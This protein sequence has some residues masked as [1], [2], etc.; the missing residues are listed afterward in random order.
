MP[1]S[2]FG[3]GSISPEGA[4]YIQAPG[5]LSS[6]TSQRLAG[7]NVSGEPLQ[8]WAGPPGLAVGA[9]Y[10]EEFSRSEF[11]PLQQAGLNAG[12]AI[13][14]TEGNFNVL[15]EYL[16][17]NL[18]LL[19]DVPFAD[20]LDFRGAIRLSDYST[21]GNTQSWNA[22]LGWSP[23]PSLRFRAIRAESVRAPNINE[24]YSPPSQNFPTGLND[25]CLGTTPTS[26]REQDEAC[27][28]A[29]GVMENIAANGGVFTLNQSDLQGISGYD[30]GNP[31]LQ[32][33][34]GKSWTV[35]VVIQPTGIPVLENFGFTIDYF[36]IQI[37]DAI[38]ST[39]CQFILDQCYSG[40]ASFCQ[41]ITRRPT[42]VGANSAGSLDLIDSAVTNSGGL[43]SESIALTVNY[44]QQIGPG[45]FR[46]RLS[47]THVLEGYTIPAA[48]ADKDP[49]AGEVGGSKD[50]AYLQL[51]YNWGQVGIAWNV[52]YIDKAYLDDQFLVGIVDAN[53]VAWKPESVGVDAVVYHDVQLTWSPGENFELYVGATNLFDEATPKI[54]TGLPGDN[55]GTETDAGTYDAIGQR[56]YAGLRV[57]F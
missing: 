39:P 9:E 51:G 24:L 37:D 53:D 36:D 14:P 22:G 21:V 41:F 19:N 48:G 50:R 34:K 31:N 54:I 10:R 57:K 4:H 1:V 17:V 25:P 5:L 27:R 56:F 16:E 12:N 44:N 2:I 42:A 8:L 30:R 26:T 32:E 52:N 15:E 6:F 49:F 33:E 38:V 46:A 3:P 40:D 29:P 23:I 55:T 20:Q 47:C 43:A 35:G 11:D 18:P 28:A 45:D 13:P 7:L